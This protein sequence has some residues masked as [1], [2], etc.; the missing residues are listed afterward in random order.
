M[1]LTTFSPRRKPQ[2]PRFDLSKLGPSARLQLEAQGV[3]LE[4]TGRYRRA[5][6]EERTIDGIVFDSKLEAGAYHLLK[7]AVGADKI[8]LQPQFELQPAFVDDAGVSHRAMT[9]VADFEVSLPDGQHVLDTKGHL[10][11]VFRLKQK[12]FLYRHRRPLHK[13]YTMDQLR[14]FLASH[15]VLT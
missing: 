4:K 14:Q 5:P 10:T 11:D 3:K 15:G 12:L 8:R 13:I 1:S 7:Q 6:K 2:R 9:Y